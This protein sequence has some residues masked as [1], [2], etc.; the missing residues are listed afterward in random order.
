MLRFE[1]MTVKAQEALQS[2]QEIAARHENQQIEP[3]HLLSALVTQAD[4]V[5]STA[6]GQAA[7]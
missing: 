6:H 4:G 1:K 3:V 2:A 5:C 7:E